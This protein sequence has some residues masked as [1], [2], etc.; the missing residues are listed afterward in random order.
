[1]DDQLLLQDLCLMQYSLNAHLQLL[2]GNVIILYLNIGEVSLKNKFLPS[3]LI[4]C[5]VFKSCV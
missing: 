2:Y 1:M 4:L 5:L 3:F